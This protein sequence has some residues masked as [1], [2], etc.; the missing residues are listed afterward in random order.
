MDNVIQFF[1]QLD[2]DILLQIQYHLRTE[3]LT[4]L[5]IFVTRLGNEG[6][7]WIACA[8]IMMIPKRTRRIGFLALAALAVTYL[9][10]SLGLKNLVGRVRPYETVS[11]L[12][13]LIEAQEGWSFP[14]GHAASSFAAATVFFMGYRRRVGI[15][16]MVL[17]GMIAFSRLYVGVHYPS[18]VIVGTVIGALIGGILYRIF[19]EKKKNRRMT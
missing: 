1:L 5:M 16:F 3:F 4:P 6:L 2:G 10:C 11:G 8:L 15:P 7:I 17:A 13:R 18:D 14:S 12:H 9:V 19:G